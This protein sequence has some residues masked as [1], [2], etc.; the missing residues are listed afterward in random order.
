[1]II[2][3]YTRETIILRHGDDG[4]AWVDGLPGR[5]AELRERWQVRLGDAFSYGSVNF[6]A[7]GT[8]ADG[9]PVVLK[10]AYD[11]ASLVPE[12]EALRL[13][14][15]SGLV[16]IIE[17]APE[18]DAYLMRRAVPGD[19]LIDHPDDEEASRILGRTMAALWRPI[20][21]VH[22]FPTVVG[23]GQGF[24]RMRERYGG[25]TGPLP[26]E[27]TARAERMYA[28]LLSTS[29][30]PVVLHGDLHHHNVLRDGDEWSAID[31]K[32]VVGEPAYEIGAMMRNRLPDL[33]DPEAARAIL[34]RR[35]AIVAEETGLDADRLRRWTVAQ[36]LLTAWW[37]VEDQGPFEWAED[38]IRTAELLIR[39][40]D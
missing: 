2:P 29:A 23:W 40:D 26:A 21:A 37:V 5:L 15:G 39:D 25:G 31:P 24:D 22:P 20:P 7:P 36:A 12:I 8:R 9:T 18:G 4:R 35:L 28:E 27:L 34:L 6:V 13:A 33:S 32:G 16:P 19:E 3:A 30:E 14:D 1:M 17:L 10:A 38:V 11:R